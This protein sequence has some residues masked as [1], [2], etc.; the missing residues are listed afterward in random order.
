MLKVLDSPVVPTKV[1]SDSGLASPFPGVVPPPGPIWF[2]S[3]M[4]T[5]ILSNLLGLHAERIPLGAYFSL[6]FL[7]VSW[8]LLVFLTSSFVVRCLRSA[9]VFRE[10][11]V[12]P[13]QIPFWGTVSMGFLSAGAASTVA[14]PLFWPDLAD[15]AWQVDTVTWIIGASIGVV[16]AVYFAARAF[17]SSLGKPNFV[18]GLAVVGP[19]VAATVGANLS[20]HVGPAYGPLVLILSFCCFMITLSLGTTIFIQGYAEIWGRS[21]LPL[22]A[23]ASS[24]IP[25]GLVGQSAAAVQAISF[26]LENFASGSVIPT[27]HFLA[28]VYDWT[29]LVIGTPLTMWASFVTIRGVLNRMPFSPGWWATTFPIGTLS[30]GAT[31]MAKGTGIEGF[32]W[33]GAVGTLALVGTVLFSGLGSLRAVFVKLT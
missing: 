12:N 3:V 24:W 9:T 8:T 5:G 20:P 21:P 25:L 14:L 16:S 11:L 6:F 26:N 32:M 22:P 17:G 2:P 15:F 18:W 33:L 31:L 1:I 7:A 28:N 10:A 4:G 30:L 29:L 23:S 27:A 13:A 19:M